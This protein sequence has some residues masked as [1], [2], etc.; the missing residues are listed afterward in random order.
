MMDAR[1]RG[2]GEGWARPRVRSGINRK[3]LPKSVGLRLGAVISF[4]ARCFESNVEWV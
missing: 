4:D 2:A 1:G 3:D